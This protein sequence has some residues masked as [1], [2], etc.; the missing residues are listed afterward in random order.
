MRVLVNAGFDRF[1]GYGNDAI[2]LAMALERRGL[3]VHLW[4]ISVLPPMTREFTR[5]LEKPPQPGQ[6]DVVLRFTPPEQIIP[7]EFAQAAKVAVGYSMWERSA[8]LRRDMFGWENAADRKQWWARR[9][10]TSRK[11]PKCWLDAMIVTTPMN[12]EAFQHVDPLVPYHVV[13]CGVDEKQ[14][15]ELSREPLTDRPVRF[16]MLGVLSGRKDPFA[17]LETWRHLKETEPRFDP[18]LLVHDM[19]RSIHPLAVKA[20]DGMTLTN[21]PVSV[22]DVKAWYGDVDVLVTTSRGE[23]NNKP[24][25]EFLA[26][27]GPVI[28]TDWSGHQNWLHD[29][30]CW[31]LP[32]ELVEI[33]PGDVARDFRVDV[34]VLAKTL[35]EVATDPTAVA[36]KARAARPWIVGTLS[37]DNVAATMERTLQRIVEEAA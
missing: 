29:E 6:Y 14:W 19:S 17:L 26:T 30:C 8:L 33:A 11:Y 2:D 21:K 23:G 4:P 16:G 12:V 13:P 10:S 5:L 24:A 27:G 22:E 3:D 7:K 25:M 28:A 37:W 36:K 34:E 1:S 31:R 35:L 32:G 18:E 15:P 9:N 20:Y